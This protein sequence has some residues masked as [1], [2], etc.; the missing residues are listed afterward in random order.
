MIGRLIALEHLK[1]RRTF[2]RGLVALGPIGVV[3]LQSL[4]FA[5]RYDYLT[6]QHQEDL[7]GGWIGSNVM[8]SAPALM[9]GLAIVASMLA[10]YEHRTNAWKQT[11]ALPV[12]RAA[13]YCAKFVYAAALLAAAS[14]L[15]AA[16]MAA[17]GFLFGFG[18]Q[19]LPVADLLAPIY[20]SYAAALPFLALQ[21]WLSVAM[22]NQALPLTIG[23]LGTVVTMFGLTL[24][25]WMPWKWLY[26]LEG[27][28]SRMATASAAIAAGSALY[29]AGATHFARKDV[30]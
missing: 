30:S 12:P 19:P 27:G 8:L 26:G 11:L 5:L 20:V 22:K 25:D 2:L 7:W 10:G 4:N 9:I 21:L 23:V 18:S 24:P 6:T 16:G 14:T 15:L 17:V 13:V 29:T 1:S 28:W 3:S